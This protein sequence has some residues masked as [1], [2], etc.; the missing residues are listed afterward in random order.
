MVFSQRDK[1]RVTRKGATALASNASRAGDSFGCRAER[2]GAY[3]SPAVP[4]HVEP[5]EAPP[6]A[7]WAHRARRAN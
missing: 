5:A 4:R 6:D 1:R 3:L 7:S 2:N